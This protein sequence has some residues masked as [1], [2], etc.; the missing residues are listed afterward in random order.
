MITRGKGTWPSGNSEIAVKK[1]FISRV[2]ERL[3]ETEREPV[4]SLC[5]DEVTQ[6]SKGVRITS[7]YLFPESVLDRLAVIAD[8]ICEGRPVQ[9]IVGS[10][11]FMGLEL[12]VRE[13]VLIPRP[14]TEELVNALTIAL[15]SDFDG[16]ILD[17]GTG[18][19]CIALALKKQ[20]RRST[21]NAIDICEDAL[22]IA[23]E[24]AQKLNLNIGF[25]Q[26]DI[27]SEKPANYF[28][29]VVS[30][31]PYITNDES[32][33]LEKRVRDFEPSKALFVEKHPLEFY[34]RITEVCLGNTLKRG[35]VLAFE[36][37]KDYAVDVKELI[38]K[39]NG[40]ERVELIVDLQGVNRHVIAINKLN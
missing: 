22:A 12:V 2:S 29:V 31:P 13:G 4:A 19:G 5:L 16:D 39:S 32:S 8:E 40:F 38:E 10:A 21:I 6:M 33:S 34:Q 27:L 7:D 25:S 37:H 35:G 11:Y 14:E 17:I 28:D 26:C 20:L 15:G 9:Y 18:S 23:E 1:W 3:E 24:N 30:N 36:C